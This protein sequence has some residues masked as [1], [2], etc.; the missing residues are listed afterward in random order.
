MEGGN[1]GGGVRD[2]CNTVNK[3]FFKSHSVSYSDQDNRNT[4]SSFPETKQPP[5]RQELYSGQY[6]KEL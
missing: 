1:V 5:N 6:H 3:F 2:I 4:Y